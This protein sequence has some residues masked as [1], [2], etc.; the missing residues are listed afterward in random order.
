MNVCVVD[1]L[2]QSFEQLSPDNLNDL[3]NLYSDEA[4]FK[5]PFNEVT[6]K[7]H[8]KHIFEDMFEHLHE[9]RF[10]IHQCITEGDHTVLIWDM[11]LSLKGKR[12]HQRHTIRGC[13]HLKCNSQGLIDWHRDYWD[14]GEELYVHVPVL[15][16][17]IRAIRRKLSSTGV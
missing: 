10:V 1:R 11:H 15:G 12:A 5:D 9:P 6:G 2:V 16:A 8:I 14:T 17:L 4:F 3:L 7:S 13:T